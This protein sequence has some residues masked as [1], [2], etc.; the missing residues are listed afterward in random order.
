MIKV[1]LVD[2]HELVRTGI[3][4]LLANASGISVV[5]EASSGEDAIKIAREKQP[6]V[7][8][9][10]LKMPGISGLE[11][12]RKILHHDPDA[13]ILVLTVCNDDV[14]PIRLLRAGASGYLTK[15]CDADEMIRAIRA[16]QAGQR[17]ISP[18]IAQRLALKRFSSDEESPFDALSE[19]EL[20]VMLMITSGKKVQD[21]AEK[22]HLSPKTVNTYRYRLFEKLG[23]KNDVELTHLAMRFGMVDNPK[24]KEGE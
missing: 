15:D 7:V 3:K 8:L 1:L 13:K 22:L 5:A 17:Y 2:D 11:A 4:S 16:V 12:T 19:R 24:F 21:I 18:Q 6:N 23:I 9:M 14:F 10:D 20:Q